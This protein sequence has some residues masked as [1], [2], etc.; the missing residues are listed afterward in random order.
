[1][2]SFNVDILEFL[3]SSDWPLLVMKSQLVSL[4]SLLQPP[5]G[6]N[7]EISRTWEDK[8]VIVFVGEHD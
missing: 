3:A 8:S 6:A 2:V 1:M 5:K 7:R 4:S